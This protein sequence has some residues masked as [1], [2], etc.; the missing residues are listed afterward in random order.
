MTQDFLD[1]QIIQLESKNKENLSNGG[2]FVTVNKAG[3]MTMENNFTNERTA[4][5]IGDQFI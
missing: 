3:E 5:E 2:Y 1:Q 4:L